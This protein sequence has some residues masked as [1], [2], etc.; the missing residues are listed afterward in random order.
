MFTEVI[1]SICLLTIKLMVNETLFN[2]HGN[3]YESFHTD[4]KTN[5]LINITNKIA[6]SDGQKFYETLT[7]H[8]IALH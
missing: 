2:A 3:S 4:V 8:C 5:T 1:I 6:S 7:N